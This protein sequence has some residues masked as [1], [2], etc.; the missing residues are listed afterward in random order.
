MTAAARA[1]QVMTGASISAPWDAVSDARRLR[2]LDAI[3]PIARPMFEALIAEAKVRG[4]RPSIISAVR[5]CREAPSSKIPPERGW[6]TYGRAIDLQ[7][8]GEKGSALDPAPY[9]AMG[10]WWE[11][12]GGVWGGRWVEEYPDGTPCNPGIPGDLCHYQWTPSDMSGR[13]TKSIYEGKS[14]DDARRDYYAAE[15]QAP[16][17]GGS[18]R[19]GSAPSSSGAFGL[20]A[21]AIVFGALFV[22]GRK[23]VSP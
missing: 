3:L 9:Y 11:A 17:S 20:G 14:C 23:I 8:L 5:N 4:M 12:Q 6:H 15:W 16:S 1:L 19:S 2:S 21:V 18:P 10:E 13:V 7:L 22:F